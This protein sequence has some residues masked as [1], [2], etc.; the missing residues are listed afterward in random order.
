MKKYLLLAVALLL[1]ASA[2]AEVNSALSERLVVVAKTWDRAS[3]N[4][5]SVDLRLQRPYDKFEIMVTP[6]MIYLYGQPANAAFPGVI[7]IVGIKESVLNA[8][9]IG[10]RP[11]VQI[12]DGALLD[13]K[14]GGATI[15]TEAFVGAL[16]EAALKLDSL[17]RHARVSK[18]EAE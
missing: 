8:A 5:N 1:S 11:G 9:N 2:F 16:R 4:P 17:D 3:S 12:Y 6:G 14:A 15:S 10:L 13:Q 7:Y 18:I